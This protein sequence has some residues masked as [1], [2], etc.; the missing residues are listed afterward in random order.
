LSTPQSKHKPYR[1]QIFA[2]I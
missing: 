1:T 2:D